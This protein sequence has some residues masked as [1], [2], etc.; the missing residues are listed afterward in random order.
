VENLQ[1]RQQ[2]LLLYQPLQTGWHLMADARMTP[3][4]EVLAG[5]LPVWCG[6]T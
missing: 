3:F 4:R 1:T 6:R 2:Y 5:A